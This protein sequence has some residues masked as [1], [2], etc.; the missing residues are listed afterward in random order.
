MIF[1]FVCFGRGSL[2]GNGIRTCRKITEKN[3]K[4]GYGKK[5]ERKGE[6]REIRTGRGREIKK[7][8]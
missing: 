5:K 8:E 4:K 6:E 3:K 7:T 2:F 1:L